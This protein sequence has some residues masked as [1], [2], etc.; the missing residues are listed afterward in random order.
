MGK[1]YASFILLYNVL[2]PDPEQKRS[3]KL[4]TRT[5]KTGKVTLLW[6]QKLTKK[7][8]LDPGLQTLAD[9]SRLFTAIAKAGPQGCWD[10]NNDCHCF[11]CVGQGSWEHRAS[12]NTPLKAAGRGSGQTMP[13]KSLSQRLEFGPQDLHKRKKDLTPASHNPTSAHASERARVSALSHTQW[14]YKC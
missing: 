10:L 3:R 9:E 12:V 11:D 1:A 7:T 5:K 6:N 4:A 8:Q 2:S 14:I 13:E